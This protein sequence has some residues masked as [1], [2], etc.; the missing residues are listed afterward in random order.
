[1][2]Q[3]VSTDEIYIHCAATPP[4]FTGGIPEIT[5]WHKARGFRTIG[6]NIVITRDGKWSITERGLDGI[7]AHVRGRNARSIGVCMVGGVKQGN[8]NIA[9]AN[10]TSAQWDA[11]DDVIA[12]LLDRYPDAKVRGHNEVSAKACPSF[13]VQSW[14]RDDF[15]DNDVYDRDGKPF[16][17]PAVPE[18]GEIDRNTTRSEDEE[19]ALEVAHDLAE[20][21]K[22][23]WQVSQKLAEAEAKNDRILTN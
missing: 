3:R 14:L 10:F 12:F 20:V 13:N 11:L 1:M 7:G 8:P 6:Y 9:E 5:T 16:V 2:A 19:L 21:R 23:L 15:E 18:E 22:L 4:S 17:D